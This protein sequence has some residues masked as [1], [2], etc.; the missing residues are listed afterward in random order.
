MLSNSNIK[1]LEGNKVIEVKNAGINK[2]KAAIKWL[3]EEY[4]FILAVG[5]DWTDEDT[6]EV[7]PESA[8]TLKV[9]YSPTQA[10][11]NIESQEELR[12]LLNELVSK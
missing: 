12:G 5:D 1:I 8:F 11:F 10:K 6:F 7:M 4:D 2:G 9:G 3:Q